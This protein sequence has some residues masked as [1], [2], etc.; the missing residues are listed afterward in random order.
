MKKGI[1]VFVLFFTFMFSW[2]IIGLAEENNIA[3]NNNTN[4]EQVIQTPVVVEKPQEPVIDELAT[5]EENN[6]NIDLYNEQVDTYNT[7]IAEENSK[8]EEEYNEAYEEVYTHNESEQ[9]KVEQNE[10]DLERQEK[11]DERI[12]SDT[13]SRIAEHTTDVNNLPNSWEE[14]NASP[15]TIAVEQKESDETYKVMNLHIYMNENDG[16]TYCSTDIENNNFYI[17]NN[18]KQNIILAE[19]ECIEVGNNDIITIYSQSKLYPNSGA[20]F[21]RC[22]EGY[23]NGYWIP[24]QEF[25]STSR[26]VIDNWDENGPSTTVSYDSGT[27]DGQLIKNILNVFVYNFLRY[28]AEPEKVIKYIPDF[29]NYPDAVIYL[30]PLNK[31][32]RLV[33]E[34]PKPDPTPEINPEPKPE[35]EPEP[36]IDPEITPELKSEP[37]ENK[38]EFNLEDEFKE[39][40]QIN[41]IITTSVTPSTPRVLI[42]ETPNINRSTFNTSTIIKT[43]ENNMNQKNNKEENIETIKE[44]ETPLAQD[45]DKKEHWALINLVAMIITILSAIKIPKKNKQ[46]EDDEN[47]E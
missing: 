25:T 20:L 7:Y 15:Q 11:I 21:R 19:W 13:E 30:E 1:I 4:T 44:N 22:L 16:D 39:E 46:K 41:S 31:I 43:S 47:G 12:A 24:T 29:W 45:N 33:E 9:Q 28:G 42:L 37:S 27:T 23:T 34:Q 36:K 32:D 38:L 3:Q 2:P 5:I 6:K 17:N 8:R 14:T 10:K 35:P 18:I 26:N 40:S